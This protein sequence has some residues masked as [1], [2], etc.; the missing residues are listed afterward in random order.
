MRHYIAK[1]S[2]IIIA[3]ILL[4][5][6]A[7]T[8]PRITIPKTPPPAPK[9][10]RPVRV[11]LVL[12][13]GGARGYAHLGVLQV[14]QWTGVPVD[15]VIGTSAG[16]YVSALFTDS[17]SA[18]KTYHV[19]M[20]ASFCNMADIGNFPSLKGIMTGWRLEKYL[21]KNMQAQ[22]VRQLKIKYIAATTDLLTGKSYMIQSGPIVPAVVASAAV[23]GI[24][25]RTLVDG[26]VADPVPV[27]LAQ[28]FHPR[29]IIAVNITEQLYATISGDAIGI[30]ER[31]NNIIWTRLTD[32]SLIGANIVIHPKVGDVGTFDMSA[33]YQIYMAGY[34]S[35]LKALPRIKRLLRQRHIA[36]ILKSQR[37]VQ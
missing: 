28:R 22:E 36:L 31:A 18:I 2:I 25:G 3:T 26:G 34:H 30:F 32:Y 8:P 37:K 20:N 7:D 14:L 21:L 16:S 1:L 35:V 4:S 33:R 15:L 10:K 24:Y 9:V 5:S 6:C 29:V 19:M 23:P 11:A 12:G 13:S 17:A 27:K